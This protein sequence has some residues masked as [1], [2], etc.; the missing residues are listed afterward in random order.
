MSGHRPRHTKLLLFDIDGTLLLSGGAGLRALNQAFLQLFGAANAFDGIPVAGRTDP[1]L[2]HDATARVGIT[3][4]TVQRQRFHDRYRDLLE[5]E[6]LKPGPRKGLMPG[7]EELLRQ[8]HHQPELCVGLLTGNFARAGRIKLKH[9]GSWTFFVCGAY[10]DDAAER[11]D[12][13]PVAVD[14]ART[15]GAV[16]HSPAHVV[17]I[18]DTPLDIRCARAAG[19]RSIAVAT[20]SFDVKTLHRKGATAVRPDLSAREAFLAILDEF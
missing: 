6:I 1:L 20:G 13:V 17:V 7:V 3:L 16:V 10:G 5:V 11:D 14:R 8:V 19:A 4:D 9:F 2:L 18:G 15:A 12:L